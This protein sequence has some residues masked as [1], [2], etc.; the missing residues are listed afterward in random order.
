MSV[1][2]LAM[3]LLKKKMLRIILWILFIFLSCGL[4]RFKNDKATDE[5]AM[6]IGDLFHKT[7]ENLNGNY[8]DN[9]D[10]DIANLKEFGHVSRM[11]GDF[12][13]IICK[14]CGGPMLGHKETEANCK[15]ARMDNDLCAQLQEVA[16]GHVMFESY[17]AGIDSREKE[18]VCKECEK[19]YD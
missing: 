8:K 11:N 5:P 16:R 17:K 1:R 4:L 2:T 13:F 15:E 6:P 10:A 7:M 3:R 18:I 19:R 14:N 9:I 12:S